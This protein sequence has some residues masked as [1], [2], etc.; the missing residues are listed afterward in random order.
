MSTFNFPMPVQARTLKYFTVDQIESA[1]KILLL[2]ILPVGAKLD[3]DH[4][5]NFEWEDRVF[6]SSTDSKMVIVSV[7]IEE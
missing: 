1:G 6:R 2:Q 4:N 7:E 5:W 3:K